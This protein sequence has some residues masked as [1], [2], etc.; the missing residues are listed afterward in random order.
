V[1]ALIRA[2]QE[3]LLDG[4]VVFLYMDN[5]TAE[6]SYFRGSAKS[7]A[8]FELIVTLYKLQMQHDFIM[9]VVW[10][11]GT[12]MIQKGT[13][14]LSRGDDNGSATSGVALSGM[15]PF[16]LDPCE[17]SP[18]LL[19]WLEDWCD[20]SNKFK[21]LEPE[22]WF[23]QAHKP[24]CFEWFLAP[25]AADAAIEQLCEAVHNLPLCFHFFA[26]PLLMTNRWRKQLLKATDV[27]FVLKPGSEIWSFSQ[28]EPLGIFVSLPLSRHEPWRLRKTKPVVDLT[29]ALREVQDS[30]H[31]HTGDILR[32]FLRIMSKLDAMPESVKHRRR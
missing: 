6:G 13:D 7:G 32:K 20:L 31:I 22:G 11:A 21:V 16:H 28:H 9:H 10:I 8:L 26:V 29:S 25:T 1:N 2:G 4:C 15:V 5:Q 24:G 23:T 17:R 27:N 14:G 19:N 3:G 12:T 18:L 30:D